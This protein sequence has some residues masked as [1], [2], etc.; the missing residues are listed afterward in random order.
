MTAGGWW[1]TA[2]IAVCS[3]AACRS[4]LSEAERLV[5]QA[6]DEALALRHETADGLLR[7]ALQVDPSFLPAVLDLLAVQPAGATVDV[8]LLLDS[9]SVRTEDPSLGSCYRHLSARLTGTKPPPMPSGGLTRVAEDCFR[10]AL[11][12]AYDVPRAVT[13]R[14][15]TILSQR[16]P[17]AILAPTWA[18]SIAELDRDYA[19]AVRAM[20]RLTRL[21]RPPLVRAAAWGLVARFEHERGRHAA[22]ERA[23]R[24]VRVDP[25][26]VA[27]GYEASWATIML[28]HISLGRLADAREDTALVHHVERVIA[29]AEST[30][31]AAAARGDHRGRM[32]VLLEAALARLDHGRIDGAIELLEPL[33]ALADSM[34]D[35]G[36]RSYVRMRL[37]RAL[38]KRGRLAEAERHLLQARLL[39]ERAAMPEIQKEVEHNLLHLYDSQGRDSAALAAGTAFI[40]FAEAGGLDPVRMISYRD[41]GLFLRSRGALAE[42][43]AL[44]ERMLEDVDSLRHDWFWAGE[45]L[46]L[47]GDLAGARRY[48]ELA[49]EAGNE[50]IR[51][52]EGLVRVHLALGDTV[53][54]LE[55]ARMHDRRRDAS[56]SPESSPV[57]P[58]VL[59]AVGAPDSARNAFESA[60]AVVALHGQVAAWATLSTDLAALELRVGAYRRAA[61]LGDSAHQAASRVGATTIALRARGLAALARWLVSRDPGALADLRAVVQAGEGS[62]GPP[63]RADLQ[64]M[65]AHALTHDGRWPEALGWLQRSA[66]TLDSVAAV[67]PMDAQQ[68]AYR[69]AQ[70]GVYDQALAAIAANAAEPGSTASWLAWS[71][72]RKGRTYGIDPGQSSSSRPPVAAPG[73]AIVDYV[74]LD[75]TIAALVITPTV[76]R[77]VTLGAHAREVRR[78]VQSLRRALDVRVGSTLDVSRAAYPLEVAHQLYGQLLRPLEPFLHGL[79]TLVIVPDGPLHLVP[80][81]ALVSALPADGRDEAAA[82]FLIDDFAVVQ[83]VSPHVDPTAWRIEPRRIVAVV[84][85]TPGRAVPDS[86]AEVVGVRGAVNEAGFSVLEGD[87]ATPEAVLAVAASGAILHFVAHARA[88]E[89]DPGSSWIALASGDSGRRAGLLE[90]RNIARARVRS[91]LVVLS[92]CETAGGRALDGEGVLSLSRSF[93]RA[94]ATATL[95]TLWS[96]GPLAADFPPAFYAALGRGA[97]APA[98][99][100]AAKLALRQRGVSAFAWA[101][102]QFVAGARRG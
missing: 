56:G 35:T 42:S 16:Y 69:G 75:S 46:E 38:V 11:Q 28:S 30:R 101:P 52:L 1:R 82:R 98:A 90:A 9:L 64:R 33:T 24:A 67:I 79:R 60:R 45:Y 36:N 66:E 61:S 8:P 55:T 44:F 2:A 4:P 68:A 17:R 13:V 14:A 76:R 88:V 49:L 96:I 34:G 83:S 18:A 71:V 87:A 80:F 15:Q 53:K 54:A 95:A 99:M 43:R 26:S 81:D 12:L 93:L 51:S 94:G 70:R 73:M 72:R 57:L 25:A 100:R 85:A 32:A 19:A 62:A 92:A 39:G 48:Y 31:I 10:M 21:D 3:L 41:V 102:Y 58:A 63:V 91:P 6:H 22:A 97:P 59:A 47:T 74:L 84:P 37:G 40:R 65:L 50:M 86:R 7:R 5:R 29:S 78:A 27:P 23:E 20:R 89:S 77:I